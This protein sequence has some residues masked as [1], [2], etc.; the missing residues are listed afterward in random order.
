MHVCVRAC[1]SKHSDSSSSDET[2]DTL[3][4]LQPS[5][6]ASSS[7]E[8][9]SPNLC[10]PARRVLSAIGE[11][12]D[13]PDRKQAGSTMPHAGRCLDRVASYLRRGAAFARQLSLCRS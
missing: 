5:V 8:T 12:S 11:C 9:H 4:R 3:T 1:L 10:I 13:D 6:M 2:C 7:P